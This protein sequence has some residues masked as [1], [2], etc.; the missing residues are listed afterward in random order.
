MQR[1]LRSA[2]DKRRSDADHWR[3][4]RCRDDRCNWQGLLRVKRHR[5]AVA[6]PGGVAVLARL[7]RAMLLLL[8]AAGLA[9]GGMLALQLM[10]GL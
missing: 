8:M 4:Y 9:W 5:R 10:T 7:G 1:V 3:R 6:A 2:S